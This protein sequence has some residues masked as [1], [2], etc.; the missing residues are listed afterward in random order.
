M[1][2]QGLSE[3]AISKALSINRG[4]VRKFIHSDGSPERGAKKRNGSIL[5]PHIPYIHRRWA[6]GCENAHQLWREIQGRG[7]EGGV[8][9]VRRYARRL[10]RL[11]AESTPQQRAKFLATNEVFKAPTSRRAGSWLERKPEGLSEAQRAF[12]GRLKELCPAAGEVRELTRWFRELVNERCP[13]R[14]DDWL[15]AALCSTASE[16]KS[17]ARSLG[18]DYE[19][20]RAALS[21]EWSQGQTEGQITRLKLLKRQMYGRANFDL[22]KQRVVAA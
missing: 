22:L 10:R 7:Y 20:V 17:F 5:D 19:A 2:E 3:H 6:E 11:L 21:Y 13:A 14:L 16:L 1:H 12:V 8:G 4:T 15:D 18:Q 9:M